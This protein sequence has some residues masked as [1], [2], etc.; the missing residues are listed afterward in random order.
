MNFIIIKE[1][2]YLLAN[3]FQMKI[4]VLCLL[5]FCGLFFTSCIP[6]KDMIYLQKKTDSV[7]V[8]PVNPVSSKPYRLQTNDIISI[9]IKA[10]DQKL[11]AIFN[12]S[13]K[14]DGATIESESSLYFNGYPVDDHGNIRI[15]ILGEVNVLGFTLDE[16]RQK[17]EK[18]LLE[19][20]FNKEADIFVNVKLAG[21]RFT[22]NG[23]VADQGTKTLFVEK[24]NILEALANAGD[25]TI[26]GDRKN[27]TVIRQFPH[28]TEMHDIDLTDIKSMQ[29][30]YYFIQPNDYI[31][32]KPLKQ[33]SWGTGKTGI[34]SLSTVITLLSLATTTF[35]LLKN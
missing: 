4:R 6:T 9:S 11:V 26:T 23:E 29:S 5:L 7:V 17:I 16:V 22:V 21:I 31:Y 18:E 35:L 33:K 20:Y 8:S 15:P 27:V 25:I 30:P 13:P 2:L 3:T 28:G 1:K 14:G 19:T 10:I 12:Q 34:E 32:V 24:L